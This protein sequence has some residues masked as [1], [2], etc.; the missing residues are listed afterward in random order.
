MIFVAATTPLGRYNGGNSP[1]TVA[2]LTGL[3]K[4]APQIINVIITIRDK[5]KRILADLV[6]VLEV[7]G[8]HSKGNRR[9][10]ESIR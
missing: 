5:L 10:V 1:H 7:E 9:Y 2:A 3:V 8:S 4:D 6:D